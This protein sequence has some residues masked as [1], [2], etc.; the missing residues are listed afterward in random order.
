[1]L[2]SANTEECSR[3]FCQSTLGILCSTQTLMPLISP[4]AVVQFVFILSMIICFFFFSFFKNLILFIFL[5]SRFLLVTYFIHISV[6]MSIP[7]SQFI[8]PPPPLPRHM[9]LFLIQPTGY[10]FLLGAH[11]PIFK[12]S[13]I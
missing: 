8:P 12:S 4:L 13:Y 1:M 2:R 6:Y 7:I 11:N 5:Y 10:H 3:Q 9:T